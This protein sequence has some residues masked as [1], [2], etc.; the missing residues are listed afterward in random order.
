M[1]NSIHPKLIEE[2]MEQ[3]NRKYRVYMAGL[4][5]G[6]LF[7]MYLLLKEFL[8]GR[9]V[10]AVILSDAFLAQDP[11][12]ISGL[13]ASSKEFSED[14]TDYSTQSKLALVKM[15]IFAS[16]INLRNAIFPM[17]LE[18]KLLSYKIEDYFNSSQG[19]YPKN[20]RLISKGPPKFVFKQIN[21]ERKRWFERAFVRSFDE[22]VPPYFIENSLN[23][24][25]IRRMIELCL[26]NG[27]KFF[28]HQVVD[29]DNPQVQSR[30]LFPPG[31][32]EKWNQH[33]S[34]TL[35]LPWE[36]VFHGLTKK[37]VGWYFGDFSHLNDEGSVFY[38]RA[39]VPAL[40]KMLEPE[41]K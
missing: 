21:P 20:E 5:E 36:G 4:R 33:I 11:G 10:G 8:A 18:P 13:M 24:Q 23:Q 17:E 14:W 22:S 16:L 12:L 40:L 2:K 34:G 38:S 9:K 37:E 28:F 25:L 1:Q 32:L 41:G 30:V 3:P 6:D 39:I 27:T 31:R 15:A 26:A 19:R 29:Y 7:G 35:S